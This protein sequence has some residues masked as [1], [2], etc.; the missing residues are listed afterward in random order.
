MEVER[1]T[2]SQFKLEEMIDSNYYLRSEQACLH[3]KCLGRNELPVISSLIRKGYVDD[4][5]GARHD[6]FDHSHTLSLNILS[7]TLSH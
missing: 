3:S 7:L 5:I 2:Q 1:Q 4:E 6:T